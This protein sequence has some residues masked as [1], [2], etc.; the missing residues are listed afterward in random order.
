L[1]FIEE[2][3]YGKLKVFLKRKKKIEKC[4][5]NINETK[6][7]NH[8]FTRGEMGL[9]PPPRTVGATHPRTSP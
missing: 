9:P 1:G 7:Q 2:N 8:P 6:E 3:L 4:S 5:Q